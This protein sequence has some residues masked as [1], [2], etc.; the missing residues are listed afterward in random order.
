MWVYP[1]CQSEVATFTWILIFSLTLT[2]WTPAARM[3]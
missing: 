1:A 3:E 2:G